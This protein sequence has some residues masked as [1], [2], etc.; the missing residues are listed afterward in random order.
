[1]HPDDEDHLYWEQRMRET[2][3]AKLIALAFQ[4][5]GLAIIEDGIFYQEDNDREAQVQLDD[6]EV[7]I[8][9]VA[10]LMDSGLAERYMLVA[11]NHELSVVF[12]VSPALDHAE[13]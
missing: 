11:N 4:R 8:A 3:I 9:L 10:K 13:G 7:D 6:S 5:I 2:K 12:S 1:M